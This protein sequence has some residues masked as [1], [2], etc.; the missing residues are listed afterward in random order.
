MDSQVPSH[1]S[2]WS[3]AFRPK[4]LRASF[5]VGPSALGECAQQ[6]PGEG[7]A[8]GGAMNRWVRSRHVPLVFVLQSLLRGC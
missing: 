5:C 3:V 7:V 6:T 1:F 8:C 4:C 2:V